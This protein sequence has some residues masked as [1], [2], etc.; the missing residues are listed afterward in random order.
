MD[1]IFGAE[2]F[3]ALIAFQKGTFA[4]S[5]LLPVLFDYVIWYSRDH[6]RVKYRQL[7]EATPA[8]DI[9]EG[10]RYVSDKGITGHK[11]MMSSVEVSGEL[12][13]APGSVR[14]RSDNLVSQGFRQFTTVPFEFEGKT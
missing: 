3:L 14:F 5:K 11:R 2:N 9:R 7:F 8:E 1:E 12:S 4:S 13:L 10:F 6:E